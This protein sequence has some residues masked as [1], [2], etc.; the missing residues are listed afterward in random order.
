MGKRQQGGQ[1]RRCIGLREAI[2][3]QR[4]LE[5]LQ[6]DGRHILAHKLEEPLQMLND[7]IQGAVLVIGRT[8]KLNAGGSFGAD[9]LFQ[10]LH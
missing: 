10:L 1:Q 2:V 6:L 5:F 9:V 4:V 3:A 7:G 8:A